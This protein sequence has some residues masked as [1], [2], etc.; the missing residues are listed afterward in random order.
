MTI[1]ELC[2]VSTEQLEAM[3][4]EELRMHLLPYLTFTRP[5]HVMTPEKKKKAVRITKQQKQE[6]N[7]KKIKNAEEMFRKMGMK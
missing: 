1:E 3:N 4:D 5:K 2:G 6:E 7:M